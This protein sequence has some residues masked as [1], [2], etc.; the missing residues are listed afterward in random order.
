MVPREDME[1]PDA[2]PP[3][4]KR[5]QRIFQGGTG[6]WQAPSCLPFPSL[7]HLDMGPEG[8]GNRTW[9]TRKDTTLLLLS[10]DLWCPRG[11][12]GNGGT[13]WAIVRMPPETACHRAQ[14]CTFG[15]LGSWDSSS[16]VV[17]VDKGR[18]PPP[19][20]LRQGTVPGHLCGTSFVVWPHSHVMCYWTIRDKVPPQGSL[21]N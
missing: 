15:G 10:T 4:G 12:M 21:G 13:S 16:R 20:R 18:D 14:D 3:A 1:G 6:P 2:L 5:R 17:P 8:S 7:L 11:I 19:V 9:S